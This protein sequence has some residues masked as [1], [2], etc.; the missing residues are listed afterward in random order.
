M[1]ANQQSLGEQIL[2]ARRPHLKLGAGVAVLRANGDVDTVRYCAVAGVLWSDETGSPARLDDVIGAPPDVLTLYAGR[3]VQK[4]KR[5][6][7]GDWR[8]ALQYAFSHAGAP[9]D[10]YG[11]R[12]NGWA[13]QDIA[14]DWIKRLGAGGSIYATGGTYVVKVQ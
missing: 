2:E 6:S 4:V 14:E 10:P 3:L 8:D 13:P 7:I 1:A 5:L 11:G 9:G 12:Y